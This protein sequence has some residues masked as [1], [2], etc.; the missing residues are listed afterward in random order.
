MNGKHNVFL[1][2]IKERE[3]LNPG[4]DRE[5]YHIVLDLAGSGMDYSVGD[6]IAVYPENDPSYVQQI[7]ENIT[8][9]VD[10]D[11]LQKRANISRLS[12]KF[13]GDAQDLLAFLK[14]ETTNFDDLQKKLLPLLPRY[15][16]VASSCKHVG[17]E[18]HL[19]VALVDGGVCSGYLCKR[20][21]MNK[22]VVPIFLQPSRNFSL[23]SN[24]FPIIMVGAG[25]GLAPFRGFMQERISDKNWLFFGSRSSET[26]FYYQSFWS[27]LV[28]KKKLKI[29]YAFSRDQDIKI[30]VQHQMVK[31]GEELWRWME[32]GAYIYVCGDAKKMALEVDNVLLQIVKNYSKKDPKTYLAKLKEDRR[33]LRDI[34]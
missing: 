27:S 5:V 9:K 16:S 14:K 19:M 2:S 11:F 25:T 29:D 17:E 24:D 33:Y 23:V 6:S 12:K 34:Y 22:F 1:A 30:Y 10:F 28:D 32:E 8:G 4:S 20:A 13:F 26:D 18:V 31:K 3:L 21:E 15:Y 7:T